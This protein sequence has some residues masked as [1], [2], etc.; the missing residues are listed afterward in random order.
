MNNWQKNINFFSPLCLSG[1]YNWQLSKTDEHSDIGAD[2]NVTPE[3]IQV[4][5]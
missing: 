3:F 1:K 2:N 5:F 4:T